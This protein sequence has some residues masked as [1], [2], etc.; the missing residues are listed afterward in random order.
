MTEPFAQQIAA[1]GEQI[2]FKR[3]KTSGPQQKLAVN[4]LDGCWLGFNT[5]TGEHIVSNKAALTKCRSIRRRNK[6]DRW[7][8]DMLLY[9]LGN[10]WSFQDGRVEVEHN[11]AE[12]AR[13]IPMVNPEVEAGP[14]TTKPR[15]EENLRRPYMTKRMGSEFGATLGCKACLEIGQPHIGVPSAQNQL[16]GKR[17]CIRETTRGNLGKSSRVRQTRAGGW[18]AE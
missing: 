4:W 11:P 1:F 14:T 5:R 12:P 10:P 6:E 13:T 2:F 8:R 3:Q 17:P 16:D 9:I 18:H 7:N 15:N